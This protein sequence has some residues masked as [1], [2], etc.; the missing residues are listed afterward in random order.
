MILNSTL[1]NKF[2]NKIIPDRT[3]NV[4]KNGNKIDKT[5]YKVSY[6]NEDDEFSIK[7]FDLREDAE[8]FIKKQIIEN[9]DKVADQT[10]KLTN[11][12]ENAL[13][14]GSV[15]SMFRKSSEEYNSF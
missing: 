3:I 12:I 11:I 1:N 4:D 2:N 14:K 15:D 8:E 5:V 6:V 10:K 9:K 13:E 7:V